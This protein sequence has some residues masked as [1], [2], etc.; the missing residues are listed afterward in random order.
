[1]SFRQVLKYL[2]LDG[3]MIRIQIQ[4]IPYGDVIADYLDMIVITMV[5]R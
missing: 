2:N 3:V 5:S 4:R 1:M